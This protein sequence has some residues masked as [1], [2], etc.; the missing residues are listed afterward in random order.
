MTAAPLSQ[1]VTTVC[2]PTEERNPRTLDID[3]LPTLEVLQ[4]INAE[5]ALV[6]PAVATVLPQ[7]AVVVD[8]A[9][10]ALRAG[11]RIHYFGAGTSGRVA[12][13]DAAELMPTFALEPNRVVAHHAGGF[14]A[15]VMALEDVEDD[16]DAGRTDAD[17]V[18]AGD[19]V[20][21]LA[22]SGRTPYVLSA[23]T[24]SRAVGAFAVL[25]SA[26]PDAAAGVDVDVHL[27][28]DTGPEAIAGSTRMKAATAQKLVLHSLSTAVMVRL[29]RTYSN[30]M[31]GMVATNAKLRGR[32]VAILVAATGRAPGECTAVL[33]DADGEVKVALV[34]LL[35]GVPVASAKTAL[36]RNGGIVRAALNQEAVS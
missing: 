14:E 25:V 19:V 26:N 15:L 22:A 23:L 33:A 27:G 11:H 8:R 2:S 12:V 28:L 10:D 21:G 31:V 17:E 5:D 1:I 6:P 29:G 32:L 35:S 24:R 4:L 3:T 9:V 13:Q 20:V 16:A 30:L 18:E 34:A 7:L 36:D